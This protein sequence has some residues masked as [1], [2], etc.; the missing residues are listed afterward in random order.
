MPFSTVLASVRGVGARRSGNSPH[1][2]TRLVSSVGTVAQ[3]CDEIEGTS[4]V[5]DQVS[6]RKLA[7]RH[8]PPGHLGS[9]A[10]ARRVGGDRD[11]PCGGTPRSCGRT[12]AA[13]PASILD[14]RGVT[15]SF[16]NNC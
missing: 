13:D 5:Q 2:S 11:W 1:V 3:C 6:R 16:V 8:A 12:Q 9:G 14:M 15:G 10:H 7:G 4:E